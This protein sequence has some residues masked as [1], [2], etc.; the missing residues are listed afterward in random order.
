MMFVTPAKDDS[1]TIRITEKQK[2]ALNQLY[3][4]MGYKNISDMTLQ[5]WEKE[6]QRYRE[7]LE[8][9]Q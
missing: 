4:V 2:E 6:F 5:L 7:Q 9:K 8:N 1:V 3:K